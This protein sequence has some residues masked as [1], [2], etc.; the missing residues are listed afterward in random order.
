MLTEP[1]EPK[2]KERRSEAKS[3]EDINVYVRTYDNS[4]LPFPICYIYPAHVRKSEHL[5][6]TP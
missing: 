4:S 1:I 6:E 5:H 3:W 2:F